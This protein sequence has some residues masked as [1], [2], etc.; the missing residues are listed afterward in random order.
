MTASRDSIHRLRRKRSEAATRNV[1]HSL[2][3][4][5]SEVLGI[6]SRVDIAIQS[7]S[8][9]I[10]Y[11]GSHCGRVHSKRVQGRYRCNKICAG[12][13]HERER[14]QS[15]QVGNFPHRFTVEYYEIGGLH[16]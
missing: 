14:R 3:C 7:Q 16:A 11:P 15:K 9:F 12:V 8:K 6:R 4:V 5:Y 2:N 13:I 10:N 1:S